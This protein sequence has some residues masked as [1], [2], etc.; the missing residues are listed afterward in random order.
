MQ[1]ISRN[2]AAVGVHQISRGDQNGLDL[3]PQII[4][5]TIMRFFGM[6]KNLYFSK[7]YCRTKTSWKKKY[8]TLNDWSSN[9][10][11]FDWCNF[12]RMRFVDAQIHQWPRSLK[13]M[14][15][16]KHAAATLGLGF[17]TSRDITCCK[18]AS[19]WI[20]VITCRSPEQANVDHKLAM[21]E[22]DN[23]T[24]FL[25]CKQNL[26]MFG[27]LSLIAPLTEKEPFKVGEFQGLL[28][29]TL[30]GEPSPLTYSD[31]ISDSN[32]PWPLSFSPACGVVGVS[33]SKQLACLLKRSC[34]FFSE[35]V[36]EFQTGSEHKPSTLSCACWCLP[37]LPSQSVPNS[38]LVPFGIPTNAAVLG[39]RSVPRGARHVTFVSR[40]Q[41]RWADGTDAVAAVAKHCLW[42]K[43]VAL[44]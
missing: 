5:W 41:N 31:V 36:S 30:L 42:K 12:P 17:H 23:S 6:L 7:S 21:W 40:R 10:R 20:W 19:T 37:L 26:Q 4:W 33:S 18:L 3:W 14:G 39:R 28:K 44:K 34:H 35:I 11:H 32:D 27:N 8:K 29:T 13:P 38:P 24:C 1:H 2:P 25:E 9:I 22:S 43:A 15:V 16:Q